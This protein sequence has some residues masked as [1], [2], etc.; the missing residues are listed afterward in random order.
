MAA[1]ARSPETHLALSLSRRL[2]LLFSVLGF[3]LHSQT[4]SSIHPHLQS[5]KPFLPPA[6][7]LCLSRSWKNSS[8]P[9]EI[10]GEAQ[11]VSRITECTAVVQP[12]QPNPTSTARNL[13]TVFDSRCDLTDFGFSGLSVEHRGTGLAGK[14]SSL[15]VHTASQS[16]PAAIR[17]L[18]E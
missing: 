2:F 10:C 15:T 3:A 16:G 11:S 17:R 6:F 13:R 4:Y 12:N 1:D 14:Y 7:V 9:A 5:I 18:L 8:A